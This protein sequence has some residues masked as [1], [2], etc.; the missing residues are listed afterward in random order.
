LGIV[1]VATTIIAAFSVSILITMQQQAYADSIIGRVGNGYE[2]G[3]TASKGGQADTCPTGAG[4][5]YCV[6]FH[7]GYIVAD[8]SQR[9]LK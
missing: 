8:Q 9:N 2:A 4:T 3:K 6:G 7:A 5:A 1:V